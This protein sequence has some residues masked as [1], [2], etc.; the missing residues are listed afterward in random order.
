MSEQEAPGTG[1]QQTRRD[2]LKNAGLV[3]GGV[4]VGGAAGFAVNEALSDED[5]AGAADGDLPES[6]LP[7]LDQSE[8]PLKSLTYLS[9][10]NART[11]QALT[12]RIF[13]SDDE[14]PG[15]LEAGVVY[16]IDQQLG[17]AWGAGDQ[18]YMEGPFMPGEPT[19][20]WQ[21]HLTPREVYQAGIRF[22]DEHC[23]E[24][25]GEGFVDLGI[26]QQDEVVGALANGQ[27]ETF[28]GIAPSDFF[29]ILRENTLE[30]MYY[31]P[32]YGGN[33]NMVG[34]RLKQYP[35]SYV[36]Y[37]DLI[38]S[39]DFIELTP[40]PLAEGHLGSLETDVDE[41]EGS[42]HSDHGAHHHAHPLDATARQSQD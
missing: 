17:G 37:R 8:I 38:A 36:S 16:F 5:S 23:Q 6:T 41:S 13:P 26:E 14:T 25:F 15:A 35:G 29:A 42:L 39:S 33:H 31:D 30:G 40:Q 11:I 24:T 4:A 10:P 7:P 22:I 19:Q 27:I 12:A 21:H 20:G 34:W 32:M 9:I 18:W 3:A 1:R 2:F 28:R